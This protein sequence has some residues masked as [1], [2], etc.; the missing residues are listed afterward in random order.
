MP[1]EEERVSVRVNDYVLT[2]S[3]VKNG[4]IYGVLLNIDNE[5]MIEVDYIAQED[6]EA[7]EAAPG[8][9]KDSMD[10]EDTD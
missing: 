9:D 1:D 4:R 8:N 6:K 10:T 7:V 2:T 3:D 5:R